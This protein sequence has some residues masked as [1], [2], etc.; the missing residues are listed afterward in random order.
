[1]MVVEL[2]LLEPSNHRRNYKNLSN[3]KQKA[4]RD[5][6]LVRSVN[7]KLPRGLVS[8]ITTQFS[9]SRCT[10]FRIWKQY[11]SIINGDVSSR[12]IY[13]G[14]KRIEIDMSELQ[15][16]PLRKRITLKALSCSFSESTVQRRVKSGSIR[17]HS[18]AIKPD[19]TP[20]NKIERMKFSHSMIDKTSIPHDPIF[21]GMYDVIHID[22]KWFYMTKTLETYYLAPNEEN[23]HRTCKSK[24]FIQKIMFLVALARPRLGLENLMADVVQLEHLNKMNAHNIAMV[25]APNMIQMDKAALLG[26]AIEQVKD[27]KQKATEVSKVFTVPTEI[28]EVTVDCD[29]PNITRQNNNDKIFI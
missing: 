14:Q 2:E 18:N 22:E 9:V 5:M 24:N 1:M 11:K 25:F 16:I 20:E 8:I 15:K 23:P 26:S 13:S 6:L 27:L 4:I 28:D 10:I 19:L 3:E 12:K 21:E 29:V 17:K 7:G